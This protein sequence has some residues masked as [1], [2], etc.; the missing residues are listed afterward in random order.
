MRPLERGTAHLDLG[1]GLWHGAGAVL[2]HAVGGCEDP[3]GGD[4]GAAAELRLSAGRHDG[5]HPGVGVHLFQT[6]SGTNM[7]LPLI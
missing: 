5:R 7:E 1:R 6:A 2:E 4:E 3:L